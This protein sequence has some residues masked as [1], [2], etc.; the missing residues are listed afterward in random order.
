MKG[1]LGAVLTTA[2]SALAL[3][4]ALLQLAVLSRSAPH[5]AAAPSVRGGVT[6]RYSIPGGRSGIPY[7]PLEKARPQP[8]EPGSREGRT[9]QRPQDE[10]H[11]HNAPPPARFRSVPQQPGPQPARKLTA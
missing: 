1:H 2:L 6:N 10:H 9:P 5:Y 8:A 3:A 7:L 11:E 4:L